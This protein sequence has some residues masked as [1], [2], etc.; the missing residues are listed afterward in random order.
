MVPATAQ[1]SRCRPLS[2]IGAN[3][4]ITHRTSL[5]K[6]TSGTT[7]FKLPPVFGSILGPILGLFDDDMSC[8]IRHHL[9]MPVFG[10]ISWHLNPPLLPPAPPWLAGTS[11]RQWSLSSVSASSALH[12]SQSRCD[13][14]NW[15]IISYYKWRFHTKQKDGF[16]KIIK[17]CAGRDW[18]W[19]TRPTTRYVCSAK[20]RVF[21]R[22][23]IICGRNLVSRKFIIVSFA[24]C[25]HDVILLVSS[26]SGW[27][28]KKSWFYWF[29]STNILRNIFL[30]ITK[31]I[32]FST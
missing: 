15:S 26:C 20:L 21:S 2:G 11:H 25:L 22:K 14:R 19:H 9:M 16:I 1:V 4:M 29:S 27:I 32:I 23:F 3:R 30:C 28:F 6:H 8:C 7:S 12:A 13:G 10:S 5:R 31:P 17:R 24:V 18:S